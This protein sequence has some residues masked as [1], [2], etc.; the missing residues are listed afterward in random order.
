MQEEI[1]RHALR[2]FDL[3]G[4]HGTS[5]RDIANAAGCKTPTVYHYYKDKENLFDEVVRVAYINSLENSR[6][7]LPQVITPQDYCVNVAIQRKNLS[8]DDMLVHRI[9][10]K[11]WLGCE[12]CEGVRQKLIDWESARNARNEAYLSKVVTS[13][14][15][16]RIITRTFL[17]LIER[18]ILFG[19]D[20]PDDEIR[21]EMR[22]LFESATKK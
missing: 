7:L 11:T 19:E 10:M 9:A 12:G 17:N 2:L 5:M 18:I 21:E 22:L 3:N 4:F 20:I 8:E 13:A 15:W 6:A 16:A 1:S 14:V